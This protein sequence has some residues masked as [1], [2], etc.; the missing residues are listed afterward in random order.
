MK[1]VFE[2]LKKIPVVASGFRLATKAACTF[3]LRRII[4][5]GSRSRA[6][7]TIFAANHGNHLVDD[8][9]MF[10][11][12][13]PGVHPVAKSSLWHNRILRFILDNLG[14]VPVFRTMDA[15]DR[16]PGAM[17]QK[18]EAN[19]KSMTAC[20]DIL[21]SGDSILIFVEG[22]SHDN[23]WLLKLKH[24]FVRMAGKCAAQGKPM[25]VQP[26]IIDFANKELF[27]EDVFVSF[28]H[29][30]ELEPCGTELAARCETLYQHTENAMRSAFVEFPSWE[31]REDARFAFE[32]IYG[33]RPADYEAWRSFA[34]SFLKWSA[35]ATSEE[36]QTFRTFRLNA[37]K[38]FLRGSGACFLVQGLGKST[39]Y[40]MTGLPASIILGTTALIVK[41]LLILIWGGVLVSAYRNVPRPVVERDVNATAKVVGGSVGILINIFYAAMLAFILATS[42]VIGVLLFLSFAVLL[43]WWSLLLLRFTERLEPSEQALRGRIASFLIR[44]VESDKS[45][46]KKLF[47]AVAR[48]RANKGRTKLP[49]TVPSKI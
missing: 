24:G 37:Q 6:G 26:V 8:C 39:W 31:E 28:L 2:R 20:S 45:I 25:R 41:A 23:P 49:G 10:P 43:P 3:F 29:P 13:G 27:R 35:E 32:M 17:A 19:E 11:L 34:E 21:A 40:S 15:T 48:I 44:K 42:P 16:S 18:L 12:L 46:V 1:S 38:A 14:G 22:V 47:H 33:E 36:K 30:I 4:L 5:A 7:A 9:L